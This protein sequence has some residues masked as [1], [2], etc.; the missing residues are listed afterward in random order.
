MS[1]HTRPALAATALPLRLLLPLALLPGRTGAAFATAAWLYV[2]N[3]RELGTSHRIP[4]APRALG[5]SSG[6][7]SVLTFSCVLT[8]AD[9]PAADSTCFQGLL[10]CE[11][12][13]SL[14]LQNWCIYH[15]DAPGH[16][17]EALEADPED[18]YLS[19][20][21]L[22]DQVAEVAAHYGLREI[23]GL[24]VSAGAYV[25]TLLATRHPQLVRGL[26]LVSPLCRA[27]TWADWA[28]TKLLMAT[29]S[30]YGMARH[31]KDYLQDRYFCQDQQGYHGPGSDALL[32]FRGELDE[33]DPESVMRYM[34]AIHQRKDLTR[35][36]RRIK[37]HC[38]VV[39][40]AHSP[41][42]EEAEHMVEHLPADRTKFLEVS[43]LPPPGL[44]SFASSTLLPTSLQE[45]GASCCSHSPASLPRVALTAAGLAPWAAGAGPA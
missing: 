11:E 8:A 17:A 5:Q 6:R 2:E 36:L 28:S 37:A 45:A 25:L 23:T 38:L 19:A 13:S 32:A 4:R 43:P 3:G 27:P 29:L 10:L 33:R 14:L 39:V 12:T 9:A 15:L 7:G 35:R 41:F 34:S 16:E 31:V 42:V 30:Y 26:I 20:T 1:P 40:G 44:A 22:A 18:P 24:G 21:D